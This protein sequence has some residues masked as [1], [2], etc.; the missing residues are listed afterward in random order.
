M[1][2]RLR[3]ACNTIREVIP[4][5]TPVTYHKSELPYHAPPIMY[6]IAIN[7]NYTTQ[8]FVRSRPWLHSNQNTEPSSYL[9][10]YNNN[11]FFP[12]VDW[13]LFSFE[14]WRRDSKYEKTHTLPDEG[15]ESSSSEIVGVNSDDRGSITHRKEKMSK[16]NRKALMTLSD[17]ID[18]DGQHGYTQNESDI[19]MNIFSKSS[20]LDVRLRYLWVLDGNLN[21]VFAP[22]KQIDFSV[23][24]DKVNH[25][26]LVSQHC[27]KLGSIETLIGG[28]RPATLG[29]ELFFDIDNEQWIMNNDSSYCFFR[30]D[31]KVICNSQ[32]CD[33]QELLK[34]YFRSQGIVTGYLMW[35]DLVNTKSLDTFF[36][37]K[38]SKNYKRLYRTYWKNTANKELEQRHHLLPLFNQVNMMEFLMGAFGADVFFMTRGVL[39]V[40]VL[41]VNGIHS[42]YESIKFKC[43]IRGAESSVTAVD[44]WWYRPKL[45]QLTTPINKNNSTSLHVTNP[46]T[47]YLRI[48]CHGTNFPLDDSLGQVEFELAALRMNEKLTVWL[49]LF[50]RNTGS[51]CAY[52]SDRGKFMPTTEDP[53]VLLCLQYV[54]NKN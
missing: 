52:T 7:E 48:D 18:R 10:Y 5:S 2:D 53:A 36:V 40:E 37:Q 6:K 42:M 50:C 30:D 38:V 1:N 44:D 29:G 23:N 20:I 13:E 22:S 3:H 47:E 35:A 51:L 39:N 32:G 11:G 28:R 54:S 34:E 41:R 8:F 45:L 27:L 43:D 49:P 4:Q 24:R 33:W 25:G 46:N 16:Q 12:S 9:E 21:F 31:D 19:L 26:D 17:E 14:H 15:N